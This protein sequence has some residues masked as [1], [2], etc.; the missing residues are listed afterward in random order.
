MELKHDL[1]GILPSSEEMDRQ[2][3]EQK[4]RREVA[5]Q[6]LKDRS[7]SIRVVDFHV[8]TFPEK[9]AK[10]AL[11][12]LS[13]DSCTTPFMDGT[14]DQLTA[15]MQEAGIDLSIVLPV[16]TN[17]AK[18]AHINLAAARQNETVDQTGILSFAGIHPAAENYRILLRA[19]REM[20]FQG[21]KLHPDY[22]RIRFDDIRTKRIIALASELDMIVVTHAGTDIGLYPPVY[23]PVDSIVNVLDDVRPTKLVAAH[24]GGWNNWDE[25][26]TKLAG[27]KVWVDTAF[28]IGDIHWKS[29]EQ[30]KYNFHQLSDEDFVQLV[31]ALGVERV[32]FATDSPWAE[33]KDY[34]NRVSAMPF[35][36]EE[37]RFIFADNAKRLLG[38][39]PEEG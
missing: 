20:G 15:S 21:I 38:L 7:D 5:F 13:E 2:L 6:R 1:S 32:L 12:Q 16:I 8:H 11:K 29:P 27:R 22:Y 17:P 14:V 25:V 39:I 19:A 26:L 37:K 23:C 30:K 34:V 3:E 4:M 36:E 31:H 10:A 35:T 18:V 33:Q 9:I 28:S 24:M